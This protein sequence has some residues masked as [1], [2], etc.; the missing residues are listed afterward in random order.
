M[1][2]T[3][4]M[5]DVFWIRSETM[6]KI[7][8]RPYHLHQIANTKLSSL[9]KQITHPMTYNSSYGRL[10][11]SFLVTADSSS[12]AT[13][14][15]KSSNPYIPVVQSLNSVLEANRSNSLQPN[16]SSDSKISLTQKESNMTTKSLLN[17]STN[18][19]LTGDESL[20]NAKDIPWGERLTRAF[21]QLLPTSQ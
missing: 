9:M 15:T 13:T 6:R 16:S 2:S 19:S 11:R 18:T 1:S 8:L 12:P 17:S 20:T 21:L 10:L 5:K 7:S 3:D 14:K 4:Q